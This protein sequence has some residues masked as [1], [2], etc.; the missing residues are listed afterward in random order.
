MILK[1]GEFEIFWNISINKN[2]KLLGWNSL[3]KSLLCSKRWI[4]TSR[5]EKLG[6]KENRQTH[7]C[8]ISPEKA[9]Q[10]ES[11]SPVHLFADIQCSETDIMGTSGLALS[12]STSICSCVSISLSDPSDLLEL[13]YFKS[14]ILFSGLNLSCSKEW[15]SADF[16]PSDKLLLLW[17]V[18]LP[19]SKQWVCSSSDNTQLVTGVFSPVWR[20]VF[21]CIL[22][23]LFKHCVSPLVC[24][25]QLSVTQ[26]LWA[27]CWCECGS[28]IEKFFVGWL[29]FCSVLKSSML[30]MA[31]IWRP[32]KIVAGWYNPLDIAVPELIPACIASCKRG[33]S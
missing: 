30:E 14:V 19:I 23:D 15:S 24:T 11:F 12:S 28:E 25:T 29:D 6:T 16:L 7:R 21:P 17:R 1:I 10:A 9:S 18:V 20:D 5:W 33:V 2:K 26:L 3:M 27:V 32:I 31:D 4:Y 22:S 13:S 8:V